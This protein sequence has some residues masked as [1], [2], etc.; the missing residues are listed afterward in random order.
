MHD[1]DDFS[2]EP[3]FSSRRH[4]DMDLRN[5]PSWAQ[6]FV[7]LGTLFALI[8]VVIFFGSRN[9]APSTA[10][11]LIGLVFVALGALGNSTSRRH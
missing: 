2:S 5:A 1:D 3:D 11:F 9:T 8:G 4:R 7:W 10:F 6:A